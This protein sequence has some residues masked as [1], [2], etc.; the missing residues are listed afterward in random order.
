[1]KF[2][3]EIHLVV[4][5]INPDPIGITTP[6]DVICYT[7]KYKTVI[8]GRNNDDMQTIIEN[9]PAGYFAKVAACKNGPCGI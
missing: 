1:M 7:D 9:Y 4:W 6:I 2:I 5:A 3:Q 8:I